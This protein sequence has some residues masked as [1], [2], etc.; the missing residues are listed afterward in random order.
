MLGVGRE[1]GK[2]GAYVERTHFARSTLS[3]NEG[4]A[5]SLFFVRVK[6]FAVLYTD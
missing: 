6:I 1:W 3:E 4:N 2:T 5:S